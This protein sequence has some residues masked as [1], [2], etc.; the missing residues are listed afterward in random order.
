MKSSKKHNF[1]I[2][3]ASFLLGA[4]TFSLSAQNSDNDNDKRGIDIQELRERKIVVEEKPESKPFVHVEQ[5]PQFPGGDQEM[6]KFIKENLKYP[7][8]DA[9]NGVQG[10]VTMRFVVDENGSIQ[11]AQIV[12]GL[13]PG[14]D[15]EALRV[16][17]MM[18]KWIPGKQNGKN[19]AVYFTL[20]IIFKLPEQ[21][22][23]IGNSLV[24]VDG[25]SV[26]PASIN[27]IKPEDIESV[28]VLKDKEKMIELYGEEAEGKDG[29][30]IIIKKKKK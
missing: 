8:I 29:V 22:K 20:P 24:I 2:A 28:S 15:K 1:R 30:I 12:R 10:R 6:M 26:N 14:C 5:M 11:D 13:S 21:E 16:V 3:F 18:P 9:E 4:S 7:I 23:N 17:R 19:V 25:K 27:D